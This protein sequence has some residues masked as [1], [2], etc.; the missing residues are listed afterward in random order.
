MILSKKTIYLLVILSAVLTTQTFAQTENREVKKVNFGYSTNPPAKISKK[1]NK[2][3]ADNQKETYTGPTRTDALTAN[4]GQNNNVAE[5]DVGKQFESVSVAEKTR[6]IVK[7]A[8]KANLSL[9]EIYKVGVGDVLFINLQNT[10]AK[11]YTVLID[12]T[13]DY[14]LAGK[15]VSVI[16]LSTDEIEDL[17]RENIKLY[18]NPQI[19]VKVREYVS[20]RINVEGLA[21]TGN[22][23]LQREAMPLFVVKTMVG[24]KPVATTV[25]IERENED[26]LTLDLNDSESDR[27]LIKQ[28]DR[29]KFLGSESE[30]SAANGTKFYFVGE[31]IC[32]GGKK[33]FHNGI[34]LIQSVF[35][36][37]GGLNDK[38]KVVS[39]TRKS[40]N[41][42]FV[43]RKYAIKDILQGRET[44][45][46]LQPGDLIDADR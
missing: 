22:Y 30:D 12:G 33:S 9:T 39:I 44:D 42:S 26:P 3:T 46:V 15:L 40:T 43:S 28:D 11:Y 21:N 10:T 4:T 38:I 1:I 36:A 27:F 16:N 20:H 17:L 37:C 23:Y 8:N 25:V 45:P 34:T 14:P 35:E 7:K 31:K 13:I 18:K 19:T 5:T 29:L 24:V 41:G 2:D 32:T 6:D